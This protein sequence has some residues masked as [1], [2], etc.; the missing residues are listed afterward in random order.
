LKICFVV[1]HFPPHIGGGEKMF[2]EYSSRLVQAGCEVKVITSNSGGLTGTFVEDGVEIHRFAWKSFFGHPVPRKKDLRNFISWS[3]L[4]HTGTYTAAPI[5]LAVARRFNKPCVVT[6]HEVLGKRWFWIEES[7]LKAALFCAFERYVIK[8]D[9]SL[10]HAVSYATQRDLLQAGIDESRTVTIYHGV[11]APPVS[12]HREKNM[13]SILGKADEEKLFL[14]FGR[15]GKTKG[16]YVLLDAIEHLKDLLPPTVRFAFVL[17]REPRN[18][19][20]AFIEEVGRRRL[21]E[22]P[23]IFEPLGYEELGRA[24][25]ECYCVIVPSI[26]EGFGFTAAETCALKHPV[27]ASDGGSLPEVVS[28]KALFFQNRNSQDL[29]EKI[30]LAL[31]NRFIVIPEKV[32]DWNP[33]TRKLLECYK[34]VLAGRINSFHQ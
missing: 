8:Q 12:L 19:R 10:Y 15:P 28:G 32:F 34:G 21:P 16:V 7:R 5:T 27:I 22:Q 20:K 6:V 11:E 29:A 30:M 31:Q 14:Y 9:Y 25:L 17:S 1:E 18:E 13:P 26:T 23:T 4:V 2:K 33:S 24:I 3:D